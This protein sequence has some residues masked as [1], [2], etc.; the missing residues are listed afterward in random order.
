MIISLSLCMCLQKRL[1]VCMYLC[2]IYSTSS[3]SV[4]CVRYLHWK[5]SFKKIKPTIFTRTQH[6]IV[7]IH[8]FNIP[9]R[10]VFLNRFGYEITKS[11]S[12]NFYGKC[13]KCSNQFANSCTD[14]MQFELIKI[15][16]IAKK[17]DYLKQFKG[18]SKTWTFIRHT[19]FS[20]VKCL[21]VQCVLF[22]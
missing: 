20:G 9:L 4:N 19:L 17:L 12:V 18:E 5:I 7:C 21:I 3:L 2:Y 15:R 1:C 14:S 10:S 13:V 6:N 22:L 8:F 11:R 16:T